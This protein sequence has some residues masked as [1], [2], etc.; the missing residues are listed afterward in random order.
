[1]MRKIGIGS[2]LSF[3]TDSHFGKMSHLS[4]QLFPEQSRETLLESHKVDRNSFRGQG[5]YFG[6]YFVDRGRNSQKENVVVQQPGHFLLGLNKGFDFLSTL[7]REGKEA[8]SQT[9]FKVLWVKSKRKLGK[10]NRFSG[11]DIANNLLSKYCLHQDRKQGQ[12]EERKPFLPTVYHFFKCTL[13]K[14]RRVIT[15][16]LCFPRDQYSQF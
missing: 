14:I 12:I 4:P 15:A 2:T 13:K 16:A 1:M 11:I 6:L 8:F 9:R 5:L 10:I 7:A 3:S